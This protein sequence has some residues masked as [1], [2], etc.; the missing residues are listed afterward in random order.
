MKHI[1]SCCSLCSEQYINE[2]GTI[3]QIIFGKLVE[4]KVKEKIK[5]KFKD[6]NGIVFKP[7]EDVNLFRI[8]IYKN[9]CLCKCHV[10]QDG[11]M[12]H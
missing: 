9:P 12:K 6:K 4:K 11:I 10:K 8:S 7:K 2:D 1:K 5:Y 3:D